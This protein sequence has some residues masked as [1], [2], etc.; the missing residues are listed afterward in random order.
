[1]SNRQRPANALKHGAFSKTV[2]FPGE[3]PGEFRALHEVLVREW[4]PQGPLEQDA[5]FT[6]AKYLF[7]KPR[8]DI[9]QRAE[10]G[11]EIFGSVFKKG[12]SEIW[13]LRRLVAANWKVVQDKLEDQKSIELAKQFD[14]TTAEAQKQM[15]ETQPELAKSVRRDFDLYDL[16]E[17]KELATAEGYM[18]LVELEARLDAMIDKATKRLVQIKAVKQTLNFTPTK[19]IESSGPVVQLPR[20]SSDQDTGLD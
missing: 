19:S 6:L 8:L 10:K 4:D 11:R 16:A 9:F 12:V 20:Q 15:E 14:Q 7:R 5:V 17:M 1:M 18:S 13:E 3:D 2:V